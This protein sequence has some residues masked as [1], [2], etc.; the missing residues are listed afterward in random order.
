MKTNVLLQ[1]LSS[2]ISINRNLVTNKNV[3]QNDF[4]V[5]NL[6]SQYNNLS[7]FHVRI[8]QPNITLLLLLLSLLFVITIINNNNNINAIFINLIDVF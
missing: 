8:I 1:L 7:K 5:R 2:F 3:Q 6:F 4:A